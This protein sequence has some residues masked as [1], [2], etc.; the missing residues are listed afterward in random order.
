MA[1]AAVALC[2]ATLSA[3]IVVPAAFRE[4]VDDAGLIAR[5]VV[6]DVRAVAVAGAGIDSIATIAIESMVKGEAVSFVSVRLPGGE[7]G[8]TRFVMVG[9]PTLRRGDRAVFL[10]RRGPDNFWRP[11][12]LSMGVYRIGPDAGGRPV[13]NPPVVAGKTAAPGV[14]VR[15]DR[16]RKPMAVTEFEALIRT[17]VL[18][19]GARRAVRR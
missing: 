16:L 17:V 14:V 3:H 13:V 4:I 7:I 8:A 10:L 5:G 12:G 15:G 9:A 11:V 2:A 1:V 19:G 6:T 18:E